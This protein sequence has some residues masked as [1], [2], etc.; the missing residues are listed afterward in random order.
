M[1]YFSCFQFRKVR[2]CYGISVYTVVVIPMNGFGL[3]CNYTNHIVIKG[4]V[5]C[6]NKQWNKRSI[7]QL[8]RALPVAAAMDNEDLS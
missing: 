4:L 1:W 3:S 7:H 5:K 8:Q 2:C 6:K